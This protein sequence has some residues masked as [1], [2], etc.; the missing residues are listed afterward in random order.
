MMRK[1]KI[2]ALVLSAILVLSASAGCSGS[3]ENNEISEAV[4]EQQER[5]KFPALPGVSGSE[6]SDTENSGSDTSGSETSD[7]P[8][9][10]ALV[11]IYT[12]TTYI[13]D[14]EPV[15]L[16]GNNS[17]GIYST[18]ELKDNGTGELN[19]FGIT[20]NVTYT[21]STMNV[22]GADSTYTL[23]GDVLTILS[24]S[25]TMIF[26]RGEPDTVIAEN[27][28]PTEESSQP[29][30]ESSKP[31]ESSVPDV[32]DSSQPETKKVEW[33]NYTD[34]EGRFTIRIPKGWIVTV[35]DDNSGTK[36]IGMLISVT[37][38][39]KK[40][41]AEMLDFISRAKYKMPEQTVESL[42]RA[43]Y[44]SYTITIL[45][46]SV[47]DELKEIMD[48]QE[49]AKDTKLIHAKLQKDG[50]DSEIKF[51]G[52]VIE[53]ATPA[54]NSAVLIR[55]SFTHFGEYDEWEDVLETI[56]GSLEYSEE[57]LTRY[58]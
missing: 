40:Y 36:Q 31:A 14:G 7:A 13:R 41:G 53:S 54:V 25:A 56:H 19:L 9:D 16:S 32:S 8:A 37:T 3:P 42:F 28:K 6:A 55:S 24:G 44:S 15:D 26:K 4:S 57:Y 2:A 35:Q 58:N 48:S 50:E 30:E 46:T 18:I 23:S 43:L 21:A 39:D 45:D 1:E 11:G 51:C 34:S 38:P 49:T 17:K 33:E 27:S 29:A 10:S 52:F 22:A 12:L 5:S 20:S 47:P